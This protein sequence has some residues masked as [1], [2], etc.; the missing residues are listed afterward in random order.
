VSRYR[1]ILVHAGLSKTGTTSIQ[2][3]CQRHRQHL[4]ERGIV[5]PQFLFGDRPFTTH[6]I[7]VTAS[8]TASPGKYGLRLGQRFPGQADS[9]IAACKEQLDNLL[10]ASRGDV[11]VL[12]TELIAAYEEPDMRT[13]LEYLQP[14]ADRVRVVAYIRS[15]ESALESLLQERLKAGAVVDAAALVGR[16]RQQCQ[17]LQQ[18]FGDDLELKNFHDA[19]RHPRGLVGSFLALLG[20]EEGAMQGLEWRSKNERLSMEAFR[21][22]SA[23]N[24]QF[25]A[26]QQDAHQIARRPHDLDVLGRL[27]GQPFQLE[28]FTGS[29]LYRDVLEEAA[30]L[31]SRLGCRFPTD[32]RPALGALWQEETLLM[33][34]PVIGGLK[35]ERIRHFAADFLR[36]EARGLRESRPAAAA[37]LQTIALGLGTDESVTM[38]AQ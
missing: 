33:L 14:H 23:I 3:N 35:A 15:P 4:L 27:P 30:W 5:Y 29:G 24:L 8:I 32:P 2:A 11:L 22:M 16:V 19:L 26:R 20:L 17:N 10:V 13:L 9:V 21:L 1:E 12:S 6:S 36:D 38:P 25:P 37:R 31:E 7:P 34:E 28:G 18:G